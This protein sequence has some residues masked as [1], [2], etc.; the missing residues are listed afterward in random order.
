L[1]HNTGTLQAVYSAIAYAAVNMLKLAQLWV[2]ICGSGFHH[3]F[4]SLGMASILFGC[5]SRSWNMG[6]LAV[7][8]RVDCANRHIAANRTIFDR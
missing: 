5:H 1:L 8:L 2:A 6:S 4:G 3:F 7:V